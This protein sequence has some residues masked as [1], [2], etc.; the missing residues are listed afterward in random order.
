MEVL[1]GFLELWRLFFCSFP[2]GF[3]FA[4]VFSISGFTPARSFFWIRYGKSASREIEQCPPEII[5]RPFAW[6]PRGRGPLKICRFS[7]GNPDPK[8]GRNIQVKGFIINCPGSFSILSFGD[9]GAVPKKLVI[10]GQFQ[11]KNNGWD[12]WMKQ[13]QLV[14]AIVSDTY[15]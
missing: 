3:I 7:L 14:L 11:K 13:M 5:N 15:S 8:N 9:L 2:F 4:Q 6:R 12:D 10:L 1:L